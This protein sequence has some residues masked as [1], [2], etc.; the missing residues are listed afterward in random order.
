[1]LRGTAIAMVLISMILIGVFR[2]VRLGLV[3]LVPNF[4]PIALALGVWGYLVGRL[5]LAGSVMTVIAFSIV[6][7]ETIHLMSRYLKARREG[8]PAPEAVRIAL[9][10]VGHALL[11][12]TVVLALGFLVFASSGFAVSWTLGFL[13]ALTLGLALLADFL[14]LPALLIAIDWKNP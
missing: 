3:S 2:S 13:V 12:T 7:D 5:G 6:D 8:L 1:M 11:T 9:R 14:L 10:A 4:I